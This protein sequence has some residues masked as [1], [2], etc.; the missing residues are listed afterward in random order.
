LEA[1]ALGERDEETDELGDSDG[2]TD[3][4]TDE[5]PPDVIVKLL[6]LLQ[7]PYVFDPLGSLPLIL[8]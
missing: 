1:L 8:Q 2:E 7:F 6:V 4:E 3:G 5:L